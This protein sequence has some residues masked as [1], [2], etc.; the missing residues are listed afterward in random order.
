MWA[1]PDRAK[2]MEY[3]E[4]QKVGD[5]VLILTVMNNSDNQIR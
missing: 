5:H 2:I 3:E 1:R 4:I